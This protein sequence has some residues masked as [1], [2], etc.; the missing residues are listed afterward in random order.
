MAERVKIELRS[1]RSALSDRI[2]AAERGITT[3]Q[4]AIKRARTAKDREAAKANV[5]T[6]AN[7]KATLRRLKKVQRA[8]EA[9]CCDQIMNCNF[10]FV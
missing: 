7:A 9:E 1:I 6:L 5:K 3:G 8:L 2:K 10:T 4:R